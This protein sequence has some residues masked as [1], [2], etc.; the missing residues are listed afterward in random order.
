MSDPIWQ[1]S[2]G[3][4]VFVR[5]LRGESAAIVTKVNEDGS[6]NAVVF[7]DEQ[8]PSFVSGL[9]HNEEMEEGPQAGVW[10]WPPR[11]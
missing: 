7:R 6:I 1:P 11:V 9:S 3:R 5:E 8:T 4:I 10:R 2:K